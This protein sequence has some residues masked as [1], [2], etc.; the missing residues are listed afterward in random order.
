MKKY[1]NFIKSNTRIN[2]NL[3]IFL[4]V[5][6]M[7]GISSGSVFVTFLNGND[8]VMVNN[9]LNDFLNSINLSKLNYSVS[10]V[11]TL[12]F[13][14][15]FAIMIWIFGISIVGFLFILIMLFVK[16]F[17]LGFSLGSIIINFKFK[18]ILLSFLYIVP[19]HVINIMV[20]ILLSSY[21]LILSYKLFNSFVKK[22]TFDFKNIFRKY[23]FVLLFSL[24]IL[25]L[26][27]LYEVYCVPYLLKLLNNII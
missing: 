10:L 1:L 16:S 18:G 8:K 6:V 21:A 11:N 27:S 12:I 13:T 3:F 23:C 4:I 5:L 15:G 26:S 25:F 2:K 24:I 9:Y 20:Y 19:H 7:I 14:L 22:T 17:S